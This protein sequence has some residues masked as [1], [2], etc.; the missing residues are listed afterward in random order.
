[1]VLDLPRSGFWATEA[2]ADLT[3]LVVVANQELSTIRHASRLVAGL[4]RRYSGER[5]SVL[6]S[7]FDPQSDIRRQDIEQVIKVPI[8]HVVPSDYRLALRAQNMGRPL[9]L[10]NHSRLAAAFRDLSRDLAGIPAPAA[11]VTA[12]G[13]LF[14]RLSGRRS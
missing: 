7:R 14:G 3:K 8:R 11:A 9:T 1:V 2:V 6:V 5:L 10:E 4:Q 13:S 12:G